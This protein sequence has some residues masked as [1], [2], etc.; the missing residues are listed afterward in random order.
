MYI[1]EL[2]L[3]HDSIPGCLWRVALNWS[4]S[5]NCLGTVGDIDDNG[6]NYEC[7]YTLPDGQNPTHVNSGEASII[8]E[9]MATNGTVYNSSSTESAYLLSF[10]AIGMPYATNDKS[11]FNTSRLAA[12]ES[13]L[14]YCVLAYNVSVTSNALSQTIVD[15]WSKTSLTGD[16][17]AFANMSSLMYVFT[18]IPTSQMRI[19]QN[20]SYGVT[21]YSVMADQTGLTSIFTGTIFQGSIR[22]FS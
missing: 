4:T 10:E 21:Q 6:P 2:H 22:V 1:W 7:N 5:N 11:G 18:D 12:Q 3:A 15:T 17:P 14:W 9:V 16:V 13:A 19:L 20:S 8:F